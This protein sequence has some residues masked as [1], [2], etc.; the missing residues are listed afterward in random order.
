M[1]VKAVA[2]DSLYC[3]DGGSSIDGGDVANGD[4]RFFPAT[5]I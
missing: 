1:R 5:F 3:N 2:A 4:M